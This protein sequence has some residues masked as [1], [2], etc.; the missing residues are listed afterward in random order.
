M[1]ATS[2]PFSCCKNRFETQIGLTWGSTS[3]LA[4]SLKTDSKPDIACPQMSLGSCA[5]LYPFVWVCRRVCQVSRIWVLNG[6]MQHRA[7]RPCKGPVQTTKR[8]T[9][10]RLALR[11]ARPRPGAAALADDALPFRA[12]LWTPHPD[13][14]GRFCSR[15]PQSTKCKH[16]ISG[17]K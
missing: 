17:S 13:C 14:G 15:P 4:A 6:I 9:P 1:I 16:K 11:R 12:H 10:D 8:G 2:G 3:G 7:K 5:V